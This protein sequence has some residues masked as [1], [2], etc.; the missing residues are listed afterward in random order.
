MNHL[1]E[2][3]AKIAI[4]DLVGGY[5]Q[6]KKAGRN[7]KGLCP[8]HNDTHPSFMVSP[9]KG[10]GYCFACNNGGD[11]FKFIQLIEK[12]DFP[13]AVK[14]LADKAGVRLPE[15]KPEAHN[16]KLRMLKVN[17]QAAEFFTEQ[18][19]SSES[20]M[21]YFKDRGLS[22]ATIKEF[23]LGL[24]SDSYTALRDYLKKSDFDEKFLLEAGLISQR[25]IADKSTFDRFR[26][27][28]MFPIHDQQ[29][30][31]VG[32][33]GRIIGEG[34]PKYLNSPDT[35][36]YNKSFVLYGLHLAKEAIKKEDL[37]IFVEGY[38]DVIAAH[39]AGTGNVIAT[40]GTALTTPQLRLIKRYTRNIAFAFDADSA[41]AEATKRAIELAQEAELNLRII[42]IP[43]G[44]DP[45][46]CIRKNPDAWKQAIKKAVRVMDFYFSHAFSLYDAKDIDGKKAILNMLL[47]L[48]KQ[49]TSSV[50]QNEHLKR[51][52]YELKTEV[53]FL[54]EDMKKLESRKTY[55]PVAGTEVPA[56][57]KEVFSREEFLLGFIMD[58]PELYEIVHSNLIDVAGFDPV[59]EKIYKTLKRV[60]N[61]RSIVELRELQ[62][63][64]SEEERQR[65]SILPLLIEEYYPDFSEEA[66][67]K[68]VMSLIRQINKK[69]LRA[70]QKEFEFRIRE[71]QDSGERTLLLNQYSQILKL[72][73]KL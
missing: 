20:G 3:R 14:I 42:L 70:S 38:M 16:E 54:W 61:S 9:E 24:A 71:A 40:S 23:Q 48:I 32:F 53:K 59:T 31:V 17:E 57:Q 44:K 60:Y 46:E 18:L 43:E 22:E 58:R 19:R 35:P 36:V 69:N 39:Q 28:M 7:L 49:T 45:D 72:A 41:G 10:I 50:E 11:I 12:V 30:N 55:Q 2:I 25:S 64:L 13:A 33:G 52:A 15:F 29:G 5:V 65:L 66:A 73:N 67:R 51:L 47:P 63:E 1:D 34:E 4:E 21:K 27:R 26:N 6:L 56:P 68:E 62:G 8:F 37:A